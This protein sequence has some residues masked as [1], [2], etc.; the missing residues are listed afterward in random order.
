MLPWEKKAAEMQTLD[1]AVPPVKKESKNWSL[2]LTIPKEITDPSK[3]S[4]MQR[5]LYVWKLTII[6]AG[7]SIA[8]AIS[9]FCSMISPYDHVVTF[10]LPAL[11]GS[12]TIPIIA[13]FSW[14]ALVV[15]GVSKDS[16][17]RMM[18]FLP[19]IL[20]QMAHLMLLAIGLPIYMGGGGGLVGAMR[21]LSKKKWI[22]AMISGVSGT[23]FLGTF[24]CG[25][26]VW[27]QAAR[28]IKNRRQESI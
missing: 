1:A 10:L 23:L 17:W 26:V 19:A 11:F 8:S 16:K 6:C 12:I 9:L 13:R 25:L 21:A 2:C 14:L 18:V 27:V 28:M 20:L 4:I 3:K 24:V 15:L 7:L 5:A 22:A